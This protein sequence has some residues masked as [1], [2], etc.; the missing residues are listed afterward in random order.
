MALG[1]KSHSEEGKDPTGDLSPLRT[2]MKGVFWGFLIEDS[3]HSHS[4]SIQDGGTMKWRE[5]IQNS[6][7]QAA[8]KHLRQRRDLGHIT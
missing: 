6:C 3:A 7:V 1:N 2:F 8:A 5:G 4:G